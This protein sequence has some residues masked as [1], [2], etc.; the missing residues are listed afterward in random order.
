[1][2]SSYQINRIYYYTELV[3]LN[4]KYG[5]KNTE[6][7]CSSCYRN[8]DNNSVSVK[9]LPCGGRFHTRCVTSSLACQQTKQTETDIRHLCQSNTL[10]FI[11]LDDGE[12]S[13]VFGN[14]NRI[15]NDEAMDR[16][17]QMKFN[18]FSHIMADKNHD[19]NDIEAN[20]DLLKI[21]FTK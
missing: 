9:C 16:L 11:S 12:F 15:P 14:F 3:F 13:F 4:E 19:N 5:L 7:D 6:N 1:M 18:P 2:L 10:P 20:L 21:L 17:I 8:I